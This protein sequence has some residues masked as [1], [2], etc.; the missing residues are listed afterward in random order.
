MRTFRR[1]TAV[2]HSHPTPAYLFVY[3]TPDD[4]RAAPLLAGLRDEYLNRYRDLV[5]Q[6]TGP[7]ELEKY[8]PEL[9]SPAAGGNFVLLLEQG[10][11]IAGGAFKRHPD[12]G[13]AEIKR[14]WTHP[15]RRRQGLAARVLHELEAQAARQGYQRI[16]LTTGSRQPEAIQLYLN[17]GY[18]ALV[19]LSTITTVRIGLPFVKRL[20][21]LA[22]PESDPT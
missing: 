2:T 12:P 10:Q 9:F 16:Y 1:N 15:Q 22:T 11:A 20:A 17:L 21:P 5:A 4:P 7:N 14:M 13:T 8:D 3:T 19:D 6:H 18:T